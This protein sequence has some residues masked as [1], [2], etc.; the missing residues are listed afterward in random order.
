M[1]IRENKVT[2]FSAEGLLF[3]SAIAA[4]SNLLVNMTRKK[5][6]GFQ[7]LVALGKMVHTP[8]VSASK[9]LRASYHCRYV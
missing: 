5:R 9:F 2:L 7:R 6:C 1:I 8:N 3:F 4:S